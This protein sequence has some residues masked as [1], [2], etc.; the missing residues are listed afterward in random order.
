MILRAPHVSIS[1]RTTH[2]CAA[3]LEELSPL[4]PRRKTTRAIAEIA[5]KRPLLQ[6]SAEER[7]IKLYT[8][9]YRAH[10]VRCHRLLPVDVA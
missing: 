8:S 9:V 4:T 6:L 2:F 3:R 1:F 5:E 7:Q 10:R